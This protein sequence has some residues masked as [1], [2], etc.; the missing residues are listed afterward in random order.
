MLQ[1]RNRLYHLFII[2]KLYFHF[3]VLGS[4]HSTHY[5]PSVVDNVNYVFV[6]LQY[7]FLLNKFTYNNVNKI[8]IN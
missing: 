4:P 7:W 2:L 5:F 8:I 1:K 3:M 6:V